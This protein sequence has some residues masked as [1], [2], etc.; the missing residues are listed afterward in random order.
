MNL[1]RRDGR[2]IVV[3]IAGRG[4]HV[5]GVIAILRLG[6]IGLTTGSLSLASRDGRDIVVP[7]SSGLCS[8]RAAIVAGRGAV[9][10][11]GRKR[12]H[13]GGE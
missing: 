13:D 8:G 2:D 12:S 6:D 5:M 11:A 1:A 4:G 7:W 9:V 10:R 3:L